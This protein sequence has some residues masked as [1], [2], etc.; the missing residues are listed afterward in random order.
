M[1][2]ISVIVPVY[3]TSKYLDKCLSSLVNQTIK[4]IEIIVI[5]DG[6]T[7][8]SLDI[9]KIFKKKYNNIILIDQKNMGI[10]ISRNNAL[11]IARG[12]FIGFV[13][14]DDYVSND[15]Y[16]KLYNNIK[17]NNSDIAVC[18]YI[19]F[20]P[21]DN[22]F[23]NQDIN[24]NGNTNLCEMPSLLYDIDYAPWNK[25]YKKSLWDDVR[26]PEKLKYEDINAVIKVFLKAKKISFEDSY[27]YYYMI[28]SSGQTKTINDRVLD[29]IPIFEDLVS[30]CMDYDIKIK[31]A[32]KYL[33]V[34]KYFEYC[35]LIINDNNEKLLDIFL[36]KVYVSLNNNFN[37][38][39]YIYIKR[40]IN[41]KEKLFRFVQCNNRLYRIYI[42]RKFR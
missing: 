17:N 27:L 15:M 24:M 21:D 39:K 19:N 22:S 16:E 14:S 6:S 26:F 8:D 4:D 13:D 37:N 11:D 25:L 29:I 28:N 38:W 12:E 33:C 7:D 34:S 36:E 10:S 35:Q 23:F 41:L 42:K 5:N 32:L 1:V 20:I 3:N 9:I 30:Y 31:N 40:G 18:N 2:K